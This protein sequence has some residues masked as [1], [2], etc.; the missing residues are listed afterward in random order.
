MH[1]F[2]T[3]DGFRLVSLDKEDRQRLIQLLDTSD[4]ATELIASLEE[5]LE[6][7]Q[8]YLGY[9]PSGACTL[10]LED[11]YLLLLKG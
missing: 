10:R 4:E 11:F 5:A 9:K 2:S 8:K 6:E 1:I 7:Y 3:T